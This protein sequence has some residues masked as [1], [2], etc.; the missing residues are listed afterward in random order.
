MKAKSYASNLSIKRKLTLLLLIPCLAVLLLVGGILFWFQIKMFRTEFAKDMHAVAEIVGA[1]STA[2]VAFSDRKAATEILNSLEA[3]KYISSAVL[4]LPD[5]T[6]F[7]QYGN[8]TSQLVLG[9][10]PQFVFRDRDALMV[11]PV[12][13]EGQQLATLNIVG[14]YRAVYTG[15]LKLVGWMLVILAVVGAGVAVLLS[16]WLQRCIEGEAGSIRRRNRTQG[17]DSTAAR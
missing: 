13:L 4:L 9:A 8:H 7:A 16:N 6:V 11:E 10:E 2:A 15:L 3:K 1:N 12:R 5:K 14:D 17:F